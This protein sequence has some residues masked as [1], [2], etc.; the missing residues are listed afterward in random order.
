MHAYCVGKLRF[1]EDVAWKRMQAANA[2]RKFPAIFEAVA[3]GRLH[4]SGVCLLAPKLTPETADEL[5]AA[6][7]NKT[8]AEIERLLAE[9]FPQADVPT[10]LA[11]LSADRPAPG[12]VEAHT[13]SRA[14]GQVEVHTVPPAPGQ[15]E[16]RTDSPAP[17][18]VVAPT[19]HARV[20]PLAPQRYALQVAIAQ[21]THDKLRHAQALLGH[22]VPSVDLAQVLDRALDALIAKL[23][24]RKF[25]AGAR[26]HSGRNSKNPRYVP[27]AVR[28]AVWQRD[29]GQCTFVSQSGHRCEAR[30]GIEFDHVEPVARGGQATTAGVRFRCR[31]HNQ[32]AAEC[33]F[34]SEFMRRKR[35]AAQE[36]SREAAL[37][38][39]AAREREATQAAAAA[40]VIPWLRQLG[41]RADEARRAAM[42]CESAHDAP[43]DA[44]VR[45][46][47]ASLAPSNARRI[48]P[49]SPASVS[50]R[51]EIGA[52]GA[53]WTRVEP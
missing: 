7:E 29:G 6:A 13:V 43:L 19:P 49:A 53:P 11:P 52:A 34:G 33:A 45:L 36:R 23:K 5:L 17:G 2:A 40:E 51:A 25:A 21:D 8:K 30:K 10:L 3:A 39:E 16:A 28:C 18:Q 22:A 50:P 37:E 20:A 32:Y 48:A 4:V 42:Q 15:V 38:R 12:Q 44:R 41:F 26:S 9:R 47:L 27:A 46:A 24:Q 14:P 35:E 1:S 31:T